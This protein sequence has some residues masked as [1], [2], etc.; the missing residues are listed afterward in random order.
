MKYYHYTADDYKTVRY[1]KDQFPHGDKHH[2]YKIDY[3]MITACTY[4][5]KAVNQVTDSASDDKRN[6]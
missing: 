4:S 2:I 3:D 1:I 6:R 5:E